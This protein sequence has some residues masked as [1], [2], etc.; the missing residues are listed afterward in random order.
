MAHLKRRQ[1][2]VSLV[3]L[4]IA[5][6]IGLVVTG[7]LVAVLTATRQAFT[8]QQ[9]NNANQESSRFANARLA[10]SLR[11]ADFWGGIKPTA[12]TTTTSV[13]G[14]GGSGDCTGAWVVSVGPTGQNGL[15][16]YKGGSDFPITNCVDP[17]NY[18]KNSDV[19]V[20]RYAD[21]RGY[22]PAKASSALP[23][24]DSTT[25][26]AVPNRTSVFI[27]AAIEQTGTIFR[28]G[29]SVP[30]NPLGSTAGRYVYPFQFEMYYLRPCADPGADGVCGTTDDGDD[31]ANPQPSLVRMRMDTSGALVSETVIEGIEQMQLEYAP[32]AGAFQA[33]DKVSS[34]DAITQVRVGL[35]TRAQARDVSQPHPG[36]FTVLG[37]C[38]YS[39]STAGAITYGTAS[40][41][42]NQCSGSPAA[43]YGDKP[44]QFTRLV[45]TQVV[46]LRN[47]VRG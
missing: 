7:G 37:H 29:A 2:G 15:R 22:D 34:F 39:V 45:S 18:V 30:S 24:F 27:L 9:G 38:V 11:M 12:I 4:M 23:A 17:A 3:E 10:W 13:T 44:Q 41:G 25:P 36:D 40:S 28:Q 14:L 6:L 33:A 31:K 19:V 43:N 26:G 42:T 5:L 8:I 1:L 16:G 20:V 35:V 32:P 46:V 47:R 21:T